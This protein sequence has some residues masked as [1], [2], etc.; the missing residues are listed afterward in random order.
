MAKYES[1]KTLPMKDV[2]L[3]NTSGHP[4]YNTSKYTFERLL[5][6]PDN[7]EA[8][9]RDYLNGFSLNVQDILLQV[10]FSFLRCG[11]FLERTGHPG[12]V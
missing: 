12:E 11:I 6:D 1:V 3:R 8:N 9:F 5:D 2:L 10:P 7:I 4:F